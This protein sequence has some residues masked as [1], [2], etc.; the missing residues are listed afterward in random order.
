MATKR[1]FY[2]LK[3][4]VEYLS[5]EDDAELYDSGDDVEESD[6]FDVDQP[7]FTG[8]SDEDGD[9]AM[10]EGSDSESETIAG[11]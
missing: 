8:D 11:H 1:K 2:C 6:D 7:V 10:R 4:V 9:L 5:N 3:K